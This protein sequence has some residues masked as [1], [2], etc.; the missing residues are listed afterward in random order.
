MSILR[1]SKGEN[2]YTPIRRETLQD[3][4]LSWEARGVLA[5]LLSKPDKWQVRVTDLVRQG[6][7]GRDRMRRILKELEA[8]HY[9]ERKRVH[10]PNGQIEWESI[11]YEAPHTMD[12]FSI[13]GSAM[14]G[15]GPHIDINDPKELPAETAGRR[16]KPS[17]PEDT[18]KSSPAIRAI[19]NV[20]GN[21]RL[22][23]KSLW[24]KLIK[25]LG[26]RPDVRKLRGC[27]E[28][29]QER[30][31]NPSSYVWAT[32]W[33]VS[34]VP[35]WRKGGNGGARRPRRQPQRAAADHEMFAD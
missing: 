16:D 15:K 19:Q 11:V 18:R 17:P 9:L 7:G 2:P 35:E 10:L 28:A 26:E 30:G 22:P 34:G 13:D 29:W 1:V 33:Y 27:W 5:Y 4:S 6:P 24:D 14:H 23:P 12:V 21:R 32:Q 8:A 31:Y 3:N 20:K 25:V